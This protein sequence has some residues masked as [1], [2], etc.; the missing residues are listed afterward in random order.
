MPRFGA[1]S[2]E[3]SK[4]LRAVAWKMSCP[5]CHKHLRGLY[6]LRYFDSAGHQIGNFSFMGTRRDITAQCPKCL[7]MLPVWRNDSAS[8]RDSTW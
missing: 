1:L 3:L 4:E 2:P 5:K 8:E 6:S 7:A